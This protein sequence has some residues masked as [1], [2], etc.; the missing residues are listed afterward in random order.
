MLRLQAQA[1]DNIQP[2][3]M[4]EVQLPIESTN[5]F[6]EFELELE[7]RPEKKQTLVNNSL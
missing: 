6:L 7:Q 2:F 5:A 3:A 4:L 1:P